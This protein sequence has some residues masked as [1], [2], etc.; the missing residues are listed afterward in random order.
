MSSRDRTPPKTTGPQSIPLQ[1]LSR[2][3]DHSSPADDE[4]IRSGGGLFG[5][6]HRHSRTRSLLTGRRTPNYARLEEESPTRGGTSYQ[7]VGL[8]VRGGS[9]RESPLEDVEGFAAATVGLELPPPSTPYNHAMR[10]PTIITTPADADANDHDGE[11]FFSPPDTDTT[12]LT[13]GRRLTPSLKTS[14]S[15]SRGQRHDRRRRSSVRWTDGESPSLSRGRGSRLGDDL[16]TLDTNTGIHRKLS[17]GSGISR[18]ASSGPEESSERSKSLSPSPSPMARANSMLREISQRVVNLS[19]DSD[20]VERSIRRKSSVRDHRR[21]SMSASPLPDEELPPPL[22]PPQSP[23][24]KVPSVEASPAPTLPVYRP[25]PLLGKTWGIFG[26]ENKLRKW[27]CEILVHPWTEPTILVLIVAQTVLLAVNAAS[28]AIYL[29]TRNRVWGSTGFDYA[30]LALFIVYT[31]ELVARTIVSG[32][33]SNPREFS[34]ID[35]SLGLKKAVLQK[36]HSLLA[37]QHVRDVTAANNNA[38]N[39]P[40]IVR[41][42]T[43]VP[44][45]GGPGHTKQQ[46]RI[47]LA[48]RAFLR[49]SFNRLDF[50]AVVSY[51][52]S[53]AMQIARIE[54]STHVYVFN[55]LSCLRIL[56]LLG[57]TAGTSII[58]RSLKK[59]APL[60][61]HVAFLICFFWLI[62]GIIGVQSFKSSLRRTCVWVGDDGSGQN[63][64]LNLAPENVQFCGGYLDAVTG[65]PMPWLK[66]DGRN[67][68]GSS[69]GYLCPQNSLCIEGSE[70]P[71]NGTVSFDNIAQSL[72]LVFVIISSNTFSDLLYYLTDSDYLAAALFFAAGIVVL[73][74][75]LV[76][77]LVA[78]I[79]S[80]FQ[81]IR[82]E[83][84]QSAFTAEN[85]DEPVLGDDSMTNRSQLKKMFDKTHWFWILLIVYD[86]VVQSLRSARMGNDRKNFIMNSES[87][88]T[89]LLLV[90]IVVRFLCDWRNFFR[91]RRNCFDLLLVVVTSI[92]QIPPIRDSGQP[93]AWLSAFQIA[94]IYRVVLAVRLTRDL[95][96]VVFGNI[97]GLLNLILFV[98][99]FTFLAA[100]LASQLFRGDFPP[101]DA[102]G[103]TIPVTFFNI[104]NSFLGMYQVFSSENWTELMYNATQFNLIW[105]TA[106]LSAI[107][108]ILWFIISNLIVMNMFI[109]VIQES[110]DVSEDEKRL[111]QVKAFLKQ[112]EISGSASGNLSL[113][114]VFKM[115]RESIRHRDALEYGSATVEQLLKEAV[116]KDFLDDQEEGL[117]K[118]PTSIHLPHHNVVEPGLLSKYWGK[119]TGLNHHKEPNPF[120][121]SATITRANEEFD[122]RA[123]AKRVVTTSENR[124][125]AQRQYLQRHPKYNVSLFIFK[126]GNPIR[127]IC[128]YLVGPGRG[129]ERVEGVSP[130]RPAWYAFS[131][132]TY[133]AIV[134]MVILACITT[135]LYQREYYLNNNLSITNWFIWTDLGFAILFTV[136]ASIKAI[137][138]GFFF[139]PHAYFRSVWGF[140]DG[141][142]LITLWI[143][144]ITTMYRD[145]GI[146][147]AVG[148]FKAL[149]ALRLLNISDT[150]RE[151]FYSVIIIG[152]YKVLA[153]GFV[154]MSLLIPFAILGV[155]L[156]SGKMQACN[157]SSFG[158]SALSNCVGEYNSTPFNW[159]VLAPRQVA[160]PWYSFDDFGSALFILFQIV[161]QEGW[162]NVM[163]SGTSVTGRGLQPQPFAAQGNAV[164]FIV[165][166]LLGAV[167]VLT[168]FISVFMRNYTEQTGVAFLT[169]E[170]RSWLELRKL[171]KQISPSKRSIGDTSASWKKWCYNLSIKKRGK[172]QRLITTVLVL[173]L[174][175]LTVDYYPEPAWWE[176]L[177][178][179]VFL[180]FTVI[181]IANIAIRMFGLGWHRF[182]RSS[183]DI[184]SVFV[185]SGI[186]I[187]SLIAL[188]KVNS[189]RGFDQVHKLFL[190]S[191]TFLL[192]PRNNQL[193]Q[194][195]KTAAASLTLIANLLATWFVL[196][197]VYAIAFTQT[198]GLT[199]FGDNESN[200][201]NFRTVPKAL[202]LLFRTS[203]GEGWNQIMEDFATIEPPL[204]VREASFFDSDCGSSSWAR[205]LFISWNIISMYIFVSLFVSMIFESFSYVYQQ[206]S[207]MS[208]VSRDEIRR[209]KQ[210]WAD[211]DP[212]GTG[213][214]SKEQFP[215]LLGEL[216]G[217][218]QMR[219]YDGDF[220][221]RT[222]KEDCTVH[223]GDPVRPGARV[224]EGID[225]DK[226]A[227]RV[228]QIPV[229]EIR[230][231]RERMNVFYQ[232]VMLTADPD[233]GI[234][235]TACLFLLAHYNVITDSRSLRLEEFLRRRARLQRVQ[236]T[237]RRNTV[238]GFFDTLHWSRRF[239]KITEMKRDSRLGGPPSLPVPEIFIDNPDDML[240]SS[241][242]TQPHDFTSTTPTYS[243]RRGPPSLPPIDT[244]FQPRDSLRSAW[245]F[246]M[247]NES[248]GS[249]PVRS[250]RSP[251]SPRLESV[252][253]SY[254]GG[255]AATR[256]VSPT[257][258]TLTISHSRQGSDAS[259]MAGEQGI[260]ESFDASAWGESIRR[261]FT[262]RRPRSGDRSDHE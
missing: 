71:Y 125:R 14:S 22:P 120:Y 52:I 98:F 158:Y 111:Q 178:E 16:P 244:S 77:L 176:T 45:S 177:R 107:F 195:F 239:K 201:V 261:S 237:I 246:G 123:A 155:N 258:P 215:R 262:T 180:A 1:D 148:A 217:V 30:I 138:D 50:V 171:L 96:M 87:V 61:V 53:F 230:R 160:N 121:S 146:S 44:E 166:N 74:L 31:L 254:P 253:T 117:P 212:N 223:P 55:M 157:D 250:P 65:E 151:T 33:I 144:V 136:E 241:S 110:F 131:A 2:P 242:S 104:W 72:E 94:R 139:T 257:T 51:W 245:S 81:I 35:R 25:N 129:S 128:Q 99:L 227:E 255:A 188:A 140:I 173:H 228:S 24:E 62:F 15:T 243:P 112:K 127:K 10:R 79:T 153:A 70:S 260:M 105:D 13:E 102:S 141:V 27:L 90:E 234:P 221:V 192:I 133:T 101:A 115:G 154:S 259:G 114:A 134:A 208:I 226:L 216:S 8:S 196:F 170:Q 194:L 4:P 231:R 137:A 156:F 113:A 149:R 206:S 97:V 162:V 122:P 205:A 167:F 38:P 64:T 232:E 11:S 12:P 34:T 187:T 42:F 256:G 203:I 23:L 59:A 168:L 119:L 18:L 142:V 220:T 251:R 161:S 67:G 175:L 159:P 7:P 145:D 197:L 41:T 9:G 108:F 199:R 91:G 3:P 54:D 164:Y 19:N 80:S 249:S 63:Y 211:F 200:N 85:I 58:L 207:G 49:H 82:E 210:A 182:R 84:K 6:I 5:H 185:V 181:L 57:L 86:L 46:Q 248:P 20:M 32:F 150:A 69:K 118:R 179:G 202:I 204:C 66:L 17:T 39:Q 48:R 193:D 235:F 93:Y 143:N 88:V 174:I 172:W 184:Y 73:S 224:V 238:V 165:F 83:S 95:V 36:A 233:R 60:L 26:P 21:P 225:L 106:W 198:F 219:I 37:P 214:I 76:N 130:Y 109:A 163:W 191:V 183:W 190:V 43:G 56:R 209:F 152:G 29:Q 229:A 147:R 116:V 78:V 68:T 222:I 89:L 75:W 100:I 218:F 186:F 252:D 135:P 169:A 126:P 189:S 124:R 92:M 132:F 236:E 47:R 240:E 28:D 103:E 247:D 40:S 213:F